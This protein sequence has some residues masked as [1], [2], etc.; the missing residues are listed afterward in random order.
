MRKLLIALT[1]LMLA[2]SAE[3]QVSPSYRC[4][5]GYCEAQGTANLGFPTGVAGRVVTKTSVAATTST[6]V[7]PAP[8]FPLT[9]QAVQTQSGGGLGLNGQ[10]LTSA[11]YGVGA[12]APDVVL[13]AGAQ[14]VSLTPP[15]NATTFYSTTAQVV[16]CVQEGRP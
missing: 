6:V 11:T 9:A 14:N 7:C 4:A 15:T 8:T 3:A 1:A 16:I 12:S 5:Q 10:T 13:V 2:G